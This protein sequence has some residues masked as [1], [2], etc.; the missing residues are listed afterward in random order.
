MRWLLLFWSEFE[1]GGGGKARRGS[2]RCGRDVDAD[3]ELVPVF[4]LDVAYIV[5]YQC[6]HDYIIKR[7]LKRNKTI[8][9]ENCG[10]LFIHSRHIG[11]I[12]ENYF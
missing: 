7:Y 3:G 10:I 4:V 8:Y 6:I 1:S 12:R 9:F 2:R 5:S 11:S